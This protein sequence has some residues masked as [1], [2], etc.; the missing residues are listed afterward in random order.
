MEGMNDELDNKVEDDLDNKVEEKDKKEPKKY[1][2]P[3]KNYTRFCNMGKDCKRGIKC[4]WAHTL[5]QLNPIICKWDLSEEGCLRFQKCFFKH[6]NESIIQY[7]NRAFPEDLIKLNIHVNHIEP[8]KPKEI[9]K[10]IDIDIE[11]EIERDYEI[12]QWTRE[13]L[14]LL[15]DYKE[16]FYDP[17]FQIYSWGEINDFDNIH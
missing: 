3:R 1:D 7:A 15:Q 17:D 9:E 10:E 6:K 5:K 16:K 12:E 13:Y 2:G 8:I 4:I 11:N 14:K